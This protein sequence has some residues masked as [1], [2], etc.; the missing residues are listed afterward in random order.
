MFENNGSKVHLTEKER[1]I[2]YALIQFNSMKKASAQLGLRRSTMDVHCKNIR[3]KLGKQ[4]SLDAAHYA[5]RQG[6][7][8]QA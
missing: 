1:E 6:L 2:L 7:L 4:K 5:V 3:N 8:A